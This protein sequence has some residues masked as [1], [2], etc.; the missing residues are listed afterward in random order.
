MKLAQLNAFGV[1]SQVV[2]CIE[3]EEPDAPSAG[4]VVIEMLACP[5]NPAE[6]LIIEGKYA[7]KPPGI[8]T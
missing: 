8:V 7:S 5:I 3:E 2:D 1:P 6:L 4:E